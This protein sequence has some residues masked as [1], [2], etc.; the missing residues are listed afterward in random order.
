LPELRRLGLIVNPVAGM[1][2]KVGL[3][4][5][6]GAEIVKEARLLG[7]YPEAPRRATDALR[8]ISRIKDDTQLFTYPEEMGEEEARNCG[9]TPS[10]VGSIRSG[11]T[12]SEDTHRAAVEMS[13]LGVDLLLFAGGDGTARDILRAIGRDRKLT[14]LG[15]PAGVK[16][17]SAVFAITPRNAGEAVVTFLTNSSPRT[18]DAEVMDIDESSFRKGVVAARLY[19]YLKIPEERRFMQSAK[20]GG[21]QTKREVIQGMAAELVNSGEKEDCLY[22]YGPGTTTRDIL[23]ELGL[24]KTL[25]GVDVVLGG[26]VIAKD[27]NELELARLLDGKKM[28][29]KIVVTAIGNQGYIFGRG[30]QQVSPEIIRRIGK[31]NIVV[32]ASKEKLASLEGRPLLVDT[33]REEVDK[34]LEGYIRVITGFND[35]VVYKVGNQ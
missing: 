2:G 19:G 30:N 8:I 17:H 13:D 15:I 12:S 35:Y 20:S 5:T 32:V 16:M 9:F 4:G 6:D 21:I 18:I 27:V 26:Q 1:G 22:I 10:V 11:E 23:A 24:E 14:V 34:M 31:E 3:K 33:G 25:L 29:A 7:A 28:K